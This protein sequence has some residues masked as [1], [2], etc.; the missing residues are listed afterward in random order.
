M[1]LA[2]SVIILAISVILLIA[3]VVGMGAIILEMR[4]GHDSVTA[5]KAGCAAAGTAVLVGCALLGAIAMM[6]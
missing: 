5:I 4:Q 3:A 6:S 2:K 1:K